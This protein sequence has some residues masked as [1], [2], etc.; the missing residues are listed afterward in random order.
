MLLVLTIL[1]VPGHLS[2]CVLRDTEYSKMN[3]II[4][5]HDLDSLS[6]L[7]TLLSMKWNSNNNPK[8][9]TSSST[10]M[11]HWIPFLTIQ[12]PLPLPLSVSSFLPMFALTPLC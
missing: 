2:S 7:I 6:L 5:G 10:L 11:Y 8:I 1:L 4:F 9:V 3:L 12:F